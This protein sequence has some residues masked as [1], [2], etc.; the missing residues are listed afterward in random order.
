MSRMRYILTLLLSTCASLLLLTAAERP[1]TVDTFQADAAP[2]QA[3]SYMGWSAVTLHNGV[4][5]ATVVPEI[6]RLVAFGPVTGG[7]RLWLNP[8]LFPRPEEA[9]PRSDE[10]GTPIWR[11]YGGFKIWPYPWTG[12]PPDSDLDG[13][14]YTL[15]QGDDW[16]RLDSARSQRLDTQVWM[17]LEL[18]DERLVLTLGMDSSEERSIWPVVQVPGSAH[19]IVP[20][21]A[22]TN[23]AE[24]VSSPQVDDAN[25]GDSLTTIADAPGEAPWFSSQHVAEHRKFDVTSAEG[26]IAAVD[27][28]HG[29]LRL[30]WTHPHPNPPSHGHDGSF[31]FND[32]Q[33]A[34]QQYLELECYSPVQAGEQEW[35]ISLDLAEELSEISL[36]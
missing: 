6:G 20:L 24:V 26:W 36:P 29:N 34:A 23:L 7:N 4:L 5:A 30:R 9:P 35:T 2:I 14:V 25:L 18:R 16:L 22:H 3:G 32:T 31:Y 13:G 11:N 17:R 28:Q 15:D 33:Q 27:P 12:W 8:D 1:T 21:A 10:D 19:A